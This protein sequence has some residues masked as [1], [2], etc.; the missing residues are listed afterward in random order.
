MPSPQ[1]ILMSNGVYVEH[2]CIIETFPHTEQNP[3][4]VVAI[5]ILC[6][7]G[8]FS[9]VYITIS[10]TERCGPLSSYCKKFGTAE[11]TKV[12]KIMGWCYIFTIMVNWFTRL[13]Q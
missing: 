6:P 13:P 10:V 7:V 2:W 8:K 12:N 1:T 11:E 5:S 9:K 3:S 4:R